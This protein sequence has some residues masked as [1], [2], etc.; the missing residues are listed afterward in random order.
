MTVD[1]VPGR[2]SVT[3]GLPTWGVLKWVLI[4]IVQVLNVPNERK[5]RNSILDL[6]VRLHRTNPS[7]QNLLLIESLVRYRKKFKG[8]SYPEWKVDIFLQGKED[9]TPQVWQPSCLLSATE[10]LN[11]RTSD[12]RHHSEFWSFLSEEGVLR[13]KRRRRVYVR[14]ATDKYFPAVGF[15]VCHNLCHSWSLSVR[16]TFSTSPCLSNW[17]SL[18][19]LIKVRTVLWVSFHLCH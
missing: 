3:E 19:L 6:K 4:L 7:R 12:C 13:R 17:D 5:I 16:R 10:L 11:C 15:Q 2:L 9:E 18:K 1:F 8:V 14:R